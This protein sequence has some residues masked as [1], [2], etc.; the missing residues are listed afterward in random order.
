MS[1]ARRPWMGKRASRTCDTGV[2]KRD[3]DLG[4]IGHGVQGRNEP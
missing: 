2:V 4:P 3:L 1:N